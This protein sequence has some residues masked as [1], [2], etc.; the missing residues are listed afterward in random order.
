[1]GG[2]PTAPAEPA[3]ISVILAWHTRCTSARHRDR[4]ANPLVDHRSSRRRSFGDG[5][6]LPAGIS[7]GH[8]LSEFGGVACALLNRRI[9]SQ[10]DIVLQ[11]CSVPY[12]E[13]N[14]IMTSLPVPRTLGLPGIRERRWRIPLSLSGKLSAIALIV[15]VVSATGSTLIAQSARACG[16]KHPECHHTATIIPCCCDHASDAANQGGPV[17]SRIRL[18]VHLSPLP[19]ALAAGTFADT[20]ETSIQIHT[21]PTPACPPGLA[22]RFVPLLL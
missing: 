22:T 20:S 19:T 16:M 4:P 3:Q 14:R 2:H 17:E 1:M 9:S 15:A 7:A 10:N 21:S 13:S 6:R 12:V 18:T 8:E 5:D 11:I